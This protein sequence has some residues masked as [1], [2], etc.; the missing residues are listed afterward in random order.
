MGNTHRSVTILV[1]N[2]NI[3]H[4]L[5]SAFD[6]GG[7]RYWM[8]LGDEHGVKNARKDLPRSLTNKWSPH[9]W[10]PLSEFGSVDCIEVD[11]D[12]G[13]EIRHILDLHAIRCGLKVMA[14]KFP[15]YFAGLLRGSGDMETGDVFVQCCLFGDTK[16]G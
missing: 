12:S 1:P 3:R 4:A 15:H 7:V 2:E 16:Y 10:L 13:K 14:E 8:H 11:E 9:T 6:S 5:S